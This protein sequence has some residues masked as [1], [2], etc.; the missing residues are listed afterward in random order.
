MLCIGVTHESRIVNHN[1][2]RLKNEVVTSDEALTAKQCL[3]KKEK[4]HLKHY[5]IK[6]TLLT[7]KY[8]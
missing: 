5:T 6:I 4:L 7:T 1:I 3:K 8:L 2:H